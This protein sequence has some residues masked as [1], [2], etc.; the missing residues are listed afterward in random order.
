MRRWAGLCWRWGRDEGSRQSNGRRGPPCAICHGPWHIR[1]CWASL[2]AL[3]LGRLLMSVRSHGVDGWNWGSRVC[4]SWSGRVDTRERVGRVRLLFS[5]AL[6]AAAS[7]WNVGRGE[8]ERS[9]KCLDDVVPADRVASPPGCDWT[10]GTSLAP[11]FSRVEHP[12]QDIH[13]LRLQAIEARAD[14]TPSRA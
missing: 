8:C 11:P 12:P 2:V 9:Q 4:W 5:A 10:R 6:A 1:D 13:A 14:C 3:G 7:P